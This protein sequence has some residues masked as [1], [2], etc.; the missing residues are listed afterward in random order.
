[1]S[2]TDVVTAAVEVAAG[3]A[4]A[5]A[6]F[7]QEIGRWWRPGPINWNDP[8][9]AIGMLFETGVGGRL[10]EL[11]DAASREGFECGRIIVWEPGVRLAFQYRDAGH[12]IDDTE[13]EIRFEP[14]EGGTRVT[15]EHRGWDKVPPELAERKRRTKRWGWTTILG[16]YSEW[17]FWGSPLRIVNV[18]PKREGVG[19]YVLETDVGVSGFGRDVKASRRSTG[20]VLTLIE[21]RTRGG[22]PWHVH[23]LDDECMYVVEGAISVRCG[24]D[25]YEAG[26]RSFV[27]LPRGIP[28]TWDVV[29][30]S[31][32]VLL[33]TVPAGLEE[34]LAEHHSAGSASNEVKDQIA[35]KYG[36][37]WVREGV[38]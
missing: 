26:P 22:A 5:F 34:F 20:G 9:R 1:M 10:L 28:H 11:Y 18:S 25:Q 8:H 29:G 32:M 38:A 21:S 6:I 31:A 3:P 23:S 36:I 30:E 14:I 7:T 35:A 24:P 33:I 13:V 16:W 17:A 4:T 2:A 27:F 15:L 37:R 12:E 19:G